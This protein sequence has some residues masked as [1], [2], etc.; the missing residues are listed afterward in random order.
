MRS[1]ISQIEQQ[2]EYCLAANCIT[3]DL[4]RVGKVQV[5][6]GNGV[7]FETSLAELSRLSIGM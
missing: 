6:F 7:D 5:D 3:D 2:G 1:I 4:T